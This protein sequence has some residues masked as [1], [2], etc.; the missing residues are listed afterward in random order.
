MSKED[1]CEVDHVHCRI[2]TDWECVTSKDRPVHVSLHAITMQMHT[3]LFRWELRNIIYNRGFRNSTEVNNS[4]EVQNYV[5]ELLPLRVFWWSR[6]ESQ[7]KILVKMQFSEQE[8][9]LSFLL[10]KL[11]IKLEWMPK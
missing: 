8:F 10:K 7:R 5:A 11:I 1:D 3:G 2:Y 4:K 9:H 6:T